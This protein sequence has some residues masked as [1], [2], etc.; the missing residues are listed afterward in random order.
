L[1]DYSIAQFV[2]VDTIAAMRNSQFASILFL[3]GAFVLF[4]FS[5]ALVPP[6]ELYCRFE[7]PAI[8]LLIL[9]VAF[10]LLALRRNTSTKERALRTA[11]LVFNVLGVALNAML[12]LMARGRC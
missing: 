1:P 8:L 3:A 12:L 2:A 10:F 11:S 4:L 5:L 6:V 7:R 9:Q